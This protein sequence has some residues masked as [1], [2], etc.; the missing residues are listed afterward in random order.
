VSVISHQRPSIDRRLEFGGELAKA[1]DKLSTIF[2]I[3]DDPT[4]FNAADDNMM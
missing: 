2:L 1:C 4:F 3:R